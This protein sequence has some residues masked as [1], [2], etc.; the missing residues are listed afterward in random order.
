MASATATTTLL[1]AEQ[2]ERQY[3]DIGF[4]ELERGEMIQSTAGGW[5]HSSISFKVGLLLGNWARQHRTGWVLS[6][7]A[8]VITSRG[9]DTVRGTDVAYFSFE[10]VPRGKEPESFAGVPPSVAVELVGKGQGWRKMT[11]KAGEYMRMGV[12]RTWII[13]PKTR[14]LHVFSPDE[15]PCELGEHDT[16][17]DAAVLPGFSCRVAEFF[18]N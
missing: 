9:P 7:G 1:T 4:C 10:R 16:L 11:E 2:F 6:N 5:R 14:T 17:T 8:G 18:E 13:D 12:E 3:A 15:P